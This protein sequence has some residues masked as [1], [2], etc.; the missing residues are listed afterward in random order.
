MEEKKTGLDTIYAIGQELR[1]LNLEIT[2]LGF[3]DGEIRVVCNFP[4]KKKEEV[5]ED[6]SSSQMAESENL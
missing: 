5:K 1:R 2:T 4:T 3:F 6:T